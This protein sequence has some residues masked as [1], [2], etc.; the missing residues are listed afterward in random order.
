MT[1]QITDLIERLSDLSLVRQRG[2][3][4]VLP[5]DRFPTASGSHS[6]REETYGIAIWSET[7]S[8]GSVA[9]VG[10]PVSVVMDRIGPDE[11]PLPALKNVC[12][13]I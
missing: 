10:N 13:L 9:L 12:Q 5:G 3:E 7:A 2:P 4:P 8:V 1:G 6:Q 11:F